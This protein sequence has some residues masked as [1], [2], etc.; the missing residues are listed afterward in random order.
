MLINRIESRIMELAL[1]IENAETTEDLIKYDIELSDLKLLL[2]LR[3]QKEIMV[4]ME[5][6][7]IK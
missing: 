1:L 7:G 4:L 5:E 6:V 3:Q 2:E